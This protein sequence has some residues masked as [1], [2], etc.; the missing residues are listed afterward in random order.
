MQTTDGCF[1]WF[2]NAVADKALVSMT[3]SES[4]FAI[5]V[6]SNMS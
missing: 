5:G 3:D 6:Q 2:C 1:A 4:V